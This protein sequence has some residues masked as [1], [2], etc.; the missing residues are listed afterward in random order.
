MLL[1]LKKSM[2]VDYYFIPVLIFVFEILKLVPTN[3]LRFY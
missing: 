1:V 2:N 3:I